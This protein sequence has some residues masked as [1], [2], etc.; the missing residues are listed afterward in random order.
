MAGFVARGRRMG[1]A[2]VLMVCG[3]IAGW[4]WASAEAWAGK[5]TPGLLKRFL[6]GPMKDIQEIVFAVRVPGRDHWYVTFGNY[7]D[8]SD[9]P[10]KELGF[11]FEDGVYWG[12]GEGGRLC[13]LNLRTGEVKVILDDPR[14]GVRDPQV[15]YEG[16][17]SC[18]PIVG[19]ERIRIIFTK[20]RATA[21]GFGN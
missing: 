7:S 13:R 8:H 9:S 2:T 5:P 4:F 11:K 10:A 19:A 12:Y 14:G 17:K 20:S 16:K 6:E 21:A 18:F 15:H 1:A 3:W